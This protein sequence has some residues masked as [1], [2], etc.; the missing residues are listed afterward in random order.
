MGRGLISRAALLGAA[1]SLSLVLS[2]PALAQPMKAD[3]D[4]DGVFDDLEATA[5]TAPEARELRVIVTLAEDVSHDSAARLEHQVAS[6]DV[7][8]RF[9]VVDAFSAV[10][11]AGDVRE[12]AD[13]P[14][15]VQVEEDARVH[16]TNASAQQSFGV[17]EARLDLPSLDGDADGA[18]GTYTAGDLVA[19]VIDTGIHAGHVDLNDGKVLAFQDFTDGSHTDADTAFDDNGHGTHVAGTVAG[20]GDGGV[21]GR[22]VA[23]RAALVGLKVLD[24]T[25]SGWTS[26][27]IAAID[28]VWKDPAGPAV[29]NGVTYGIEAINLSL[30]GTGCV[31]GTDAESM[32]VNNAAA[33]GYVVS[34]AAG[35]DGP[36]GCTSTSGISSPAA[37]RDAITVGAMADLAQSGFY[38]AGFSSRGPTLDGRTKP[39][40]SA[41]G[42]GIRSARHGSATQYATMSGT[43]MAT[44]FVTG[45]ALLMR[46]LNP[47]LTPSQVKQKLM[48]TAVDWGSTGADSDYGA[49][50]L[51]AY[52]ALA[53]ASSPAAPELVSPPTVPF[54]ERIESNL[55]G[56]KGAKRF[57]TVSATGG[58]PLALGLTVGDPLS[59]FDMF[60]YNAAGDLVAKAETPY[61]QDELHLAAPTAGPYTLRVESWAGSGTFF[62]DVSGG[63]ATEQGVVAAPVNSSVPEVTG[64]AAVGQTLTASNGSWSGNP[65]F[66]YEWQR[67]AA[68]GTDC[69][70]TGDTD[71]AYVVTAADAG[72]GIRV[73][74]TANNAGGS[75]VAHSALVQV[76]AEPA[77]TTAPMATGDSGG[78]VP[79]TA[80]EVAPTAPTA[81][82]EPDPAPVSSPDPLET[83]TEPSTV[84]PPTAIRP[85][86][87]TRPVIARSPERG[88]PVRGHGGSWWGTPTMRFRVQWLRCSG[89]CRP[90][91]GATAAV[92]VPRRADI[93]HRLRMRVT[94]RN[95]AG[96]RRG[97]SAATP[98]VRARRGPAG[99]AVNRWRLNVRIADEQGQRP[100]A[101]TVRLPTARD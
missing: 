87:L 28:W 77:G 8:R 22:G 89:T 101:V 16:A 5:R 53:S 48:A 82:A 90:I 18:P 30:G 9:G 79:E 51:D 70:A 35:N 20:D 31:D 68:S 45:V 67:C 2:A 93:G 99:T 27:V 29:P 80:P 15:V 85:S 39:D 64:T 43:S 88:V 84:A 42:V 10:V 65:T 72:H 40:I 75:A 54:Y 36:K 26:D 1:A 100:R 63:D 17:T 25:G 76:P 60:L 86:W 3:L 81:P 32:A 14:G 96:P 69:A 44:P 23:P 24:S 97:V 57:Y 52:A 37:A 83:V 55:A 6:L 41:P 58:A 66:A 19:A 38:L 34:V 49:G 47:L 50:R 92:Y 56:G 62:L 11:E 4:R 94:V 59:D 46:D 74:V 21:D 13:A 98:V 7:K 12:L 91:E 61:R 73:A 71:A 78:D 33:A 95:A